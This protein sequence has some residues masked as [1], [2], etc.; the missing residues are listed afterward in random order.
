MAPQLA[1]SDQEMQNPCRIRC[2]QCH[3]QH[4][5]SDPEPSLSPFSPGHDALMSK[6][7]DFFHVVL[8][9]QNIVSDENHL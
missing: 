4:Q 2:H 6:I 7:R 8:H 5:R 1:L 3:R 9:Y